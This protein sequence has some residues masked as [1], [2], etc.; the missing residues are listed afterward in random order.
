[1]K[2]FTDVLGP[3]KRLYGILPS[4][5]RRG[6]VLV[7]AI[8]LLAAMFETASVASILPFMAVVMD[9]SVIT[10]YPSIEKALDLIGVTSSTG[11][12]ITAG[13]LT[14]TV[15]ALGNSISALNL[16]S[17]TRYIAL[18]RKVLS[19]ELFK[20]YMHLP[21]AFHVQ[22]DS[23]SLGRVMGAD[24]E[25]ALGGFLASLLGVVSKGL[26]GLVLICLIIAVDPF[27]ALGTVVVLGGGYY[28]V[29]R[30]IREHQSKLGARMIEVGEQIGRAS[31]EGIA[32]L[33]ELRVLGRESTSI[34][35]YNDSLT[36]L[37]E[38]QASNLLAAA[39]PRYFIEVFAYAG[40]V[41]VTLIFVLKGEGTAAVPSLA[42]YAL[43]GN[44]LVPIF[45]Q[46]FSAAITIKY[47]TRAVAALED[48]LA[49]VRNHMASDASETKETISFS[50]AVELKNITFKYISATKPALNNVTLTIA[51]N[52][53]VGFV[54]R[55]GSG[56]TTLADIILG[57]FHPSE[58][59]I[60]IDGVKLTGNN[61]RAWRQRVGYVPQ[62]VF[63]TN[64][65]IANNIALGV[66]FDQVDET[67][68][69][70]A[71][72]MAQADDFI[73]Q[74]PEGYDTIVGERGVKLSGGQRQRLGIARALYHNPD[75][76][77]F[78]EATSALDGMTEDAVMEAVQSLSS[79]R[80]MILIAHRLRTVQA[81]DRII[82]LEG[83]TVVADGSY[84]GLMK[85]S[86][87]F[88]KLAGI[89]E[90]T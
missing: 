66:P 24:V 54:G 48:D 49:L 18:E 53:S 1:M 38:T 41:A 28:W 57:L 72:K 22:R 86:S 16:W 21:Y 79:N 80:T 23:A 17:Q 71:A 14:V 89:V 4:S 37:T 52:Q 15:L 51:Q 30:M 59:A 63:L 31:R 69:R 84:D 11:A 78:D 64:A 56:K 55:T 68:I 73:E 67:A 7:V 39:L 58:G 62:H 81:C 70:H 47:H 90:S 6:L 76:L 40:I 36:I 3:F 85:N 50:N 45:Q 75:V 2:I 10:N 29:Y 32:A 77:V 35:L 83:G 87:R 26:S 13:V 65:T 42:L 60:Y 8:S 5:S 74:L 46:F 27:V 19:S 82:M 61:E 88:Q 44:R 34:E 20:G 43:A 25:S 12:V 9:P 33:K